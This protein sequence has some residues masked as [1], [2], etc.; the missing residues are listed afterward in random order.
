[1]TKLFFTSDNR[2]AVNSFARVVTL[3][4]CM[5]FF[6]PAILAQ[7][8][9]GNYTINS[10][11]PT[12]GNNFQSFGAFAGSL[13]A[14]GISGHVTA[15]V[16]PGSG[17]YTEQVIFSAV[18]GAGPAAIVSIEGNGESITAVTTSSNRYV[19]RLSNIQYFNINNLKINWNT[20]STSGFFGI[21]LYQSANRVTISNCTVNMSG[22]TSASYGGL[23][24]SGST[25]SILSAGTYDNLMFQGNTVTGGGYGISV[26]GLAANQA[27]HVTITSNTVLSCQTSGIYV[28]ESTG[29]VIS[30]NYLDKLTTNAATCNMIYLATNN[31]YSRVFGNIL[32]LTT[33]ANGTSTIRGIYV[34]SGN[35]N[36]VYNNV[37]HNINLVTG[38]FTAIEFRASTVPNEIT[39][40]TIAIDNTATT[41]G[42]RYGI[43]EAQANSNAYLRNNILNLLQ[44]STGLKAGLVIY[45]SSTITSAVNSNYNNFFVGPD[46]NPVQKGTSS[47]TVYP[48]LVDWQLASGQDLN[49][50]AANPL[51][52]SALLS[53]P[54]NPFLD[55]KGITISYVT[56]DITGI[57]RANPPDPGAYEMNTSP[58]APPDTILGPHTFCLGSFTSVQY[59]VNQVPGALSYDWTV[60]G[61]A[62]ITAGQGTTT[63][64]VDPGTTSFTVNVSAVNTAGNSPPAQ[65]AVNIHPLP[66]VVLDLNPDS[67]CLNAVPIALS[68]GM[69][70]NG[71][72]SGN[73]VT[74]GMFD[75]NAAGPG[76][77]LI[78]YAFADSNN[79]I[80]SVFDSIYVDICTAIPQVQAA[81]SARLIPNPANQQFQILMRGN[82]T[83]LVLIT[84]MD[85]KTILE[86]KIEGP[87][88]LISC[89]SW[90]PGLYYIRIFNKNGEVSG[91]KLMIFRGE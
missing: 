67:I 75:P 59:S 70:P 48:A 57:P 83:G 61:G 37:I 32:Q 16:V 28:R 38:N 88:T 56:V 90:S 10:A 36:Q 15:S 49:S 72:Y 89:R 42:N 77:H 55:N 19:I 34:Y 44:P 43:V 8:L 68:G 76:F 79:C 86:E 23:V 35:G 64:T 18:T 87:A 84:G 53:V 62:A 1:V 74:N 46:G 91:T 40:N 7:P 4:A 82:E 22:T 39:F 71:T 66:V 6:A 85:G 33:T 11:Q 5:L 58:P 24:A 21:H 14:N 73:N 60:S 29:A 9:A 45:T 13:A 80:S 31:H 54:T 69:P 51:F 30:D 52:F 81:P 17:P 2:A 50:L 25:T 78:S 26:Y 63:I 27:S 65:L 41:T 3:S 12:G 20:A 47:P